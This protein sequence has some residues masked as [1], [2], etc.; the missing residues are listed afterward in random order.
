MRTIMASVT[1]MT[2]SVK[3]SFAN[4]R[5]RLNAGVR[6]SPVRAG[7]APMSGDKSVSRRDAFKIGTS[8]LQLLMAS[9][10]WALIPG[11]DDEDE[12]C[13]LAIDYVVSCTRLERRTWQ[14]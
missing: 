5:S 11:N 4:T 10:A 13:V 3:P 12:E 1:M 14:T 6:R 8:A 2:V 9:K 7:A